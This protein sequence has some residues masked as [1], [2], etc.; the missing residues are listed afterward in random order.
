MP[1]KNSMKTISLGDFRLED[2]M[3]KI[4]T[5]YPPPASVKVCFPFFL[6]IN[7]SINW[8]PLTPRVFTLHTTAEE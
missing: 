3:E 7:R 4:K 2:N 6:L 1:H 5:S 8:A